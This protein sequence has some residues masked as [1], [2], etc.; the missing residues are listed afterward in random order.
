[1][2]LLFYHMFHLL[3]LFIDFLVTDVAGIP[4][5]LARAIAKIIK[6]AIGRFNIQQNAK[7]LLQP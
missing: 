6:E 3:F 4:V 1:M 7:L 2:E 5:P